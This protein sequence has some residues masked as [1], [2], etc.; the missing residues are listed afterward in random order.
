WR[1][2]GNSWRAWAAMEF[3]RC[4]IRRQLNLSIAGA[5]LLAMGLAGC[6]LDMQDQPK[7][8]PLRMSDFYADLRSSRPLVPGTVARGQLRADAYFYTGI[9]NGNPGEV[10]PF[11]ATKEVLERGRERFNIYCAPCHSRTG[12]G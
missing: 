12:D 1:K 5:A 8:K 3:R 9:V 6:R 10:M 11:A 7:Y 4:R 2:R